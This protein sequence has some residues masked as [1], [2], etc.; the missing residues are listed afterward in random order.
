MQRIQT[1]VFDGIGVS[2]ETAVFEPLY[3]AIH[4]F[5]H[6]V[7]KR[8]RHTLDIHFIAF[9][10]FRL[11]KYLM[12]FFVGKPHDLG[13]YRRAVSRTYTRYRAVVEGRAVYVVHDNLVRFFVGV[14][15]IA[16]F[17]VFYFALRHKTERGDVFAVLN[18]RFIKIDT[19]TVNPCG[20]ARL[21]ADK[22]E[23][24]RPEA[25]AQFFRRRIA[26]R[27]AL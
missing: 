8:R 22:F 21:K 2:C 11:N 4:F 3:R 17:D 13:F 16:R 10:S 19:V 23:P 20:S 9:I 24:C 26:P 5:L 12:P 25:V 1:V 7:R 15:K 6:V 18:F 14:G 27:S